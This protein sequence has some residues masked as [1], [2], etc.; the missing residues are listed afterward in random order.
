MKKVSL[1]LEAEV[2]HI[3]GSPISTKIEKVGSM[4]SIFCQAI[5]GFIKDLNEIC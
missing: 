3:R 4:E 1:C 2:F 5:N